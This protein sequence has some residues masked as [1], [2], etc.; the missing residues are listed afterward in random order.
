MNLTIASLAAL[1]EFLLGILA[2][3]KQLSKEDNIHAMHFH[4]WLI[5]RGQDWGYSKNM[6][7]IHIFLVSFFFSLFFSL[8]E[9][10]CIA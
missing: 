7:Y 5:T 2:K 3:L 9:L 10:K 4:L 8:E 6:E 1:L